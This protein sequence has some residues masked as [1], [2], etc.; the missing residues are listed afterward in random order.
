MTRPDDEKLMAYADGVLAPAERAEIAAYLETDAGARRA[1]EQFH[2][3]GRLARLALADAVCEPVPQRLIDAAMG[4]ASR[5]ENI[6]QLSR[7]RPA[8]LFNQ[9]GF[10]LAALA[11]CLALVI[12]AGGGAWFAQRPTPAAAFLALGGVDPAS[13]MGQALETQLSGAGLSLDGGAEAR[14]VA[15]LATFRDRANRVC[16]EVELQKSGAERTPI[17]AGVACRDALAG[18]WAM[19]G[20]AQIAE[21]DGDGNW[22]APS[23]ADDSDALQGLLNALGAKAALTPDAERTLLESKWQ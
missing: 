13:P 7:P 17:A 5:G 10:T 15:V 6:V 11:A 8:T 1:V 14:R 20:A 12:G 19:V 16:R 21:L 4:A 18:T 3:S 23:G 22:Y 2:E 9:R